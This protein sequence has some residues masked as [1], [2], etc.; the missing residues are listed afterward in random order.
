[1]VRVFADLIGPQMGHLAIGGRFD[2]FA[3]CLEQLD[4]QK[5][6]MI[7]RLVLGWNA[8]PFVIRVKRIGH[9]TAFG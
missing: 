6:I 3:I 8:Q 7:G 2:D 5:P 9:C 1:M 4:A